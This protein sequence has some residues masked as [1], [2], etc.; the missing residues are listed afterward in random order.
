MIEA[1]E[2]GATSVQNRAWK[3]LSLRPVVLSLALETSVPQM[4][5]SPPSKARGDKIKRDGD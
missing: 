3:I 2:T 4:V 5:A 1:F